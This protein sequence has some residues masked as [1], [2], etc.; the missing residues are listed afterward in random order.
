MELYDKDSYKTELYA[1]VV[2]DISSPRL[3]KVFTYK[4]PAELKYEVYAGCPV[5]VS[6]GSIKALRTAYI[7]DFISEAEL[8]LDRERIKEVYSLAEGE[9]SAQAK[10]I[11]LAYWI[12]NH[13]GTT[14]YKALMTVMPV[15][16]KVLS[17][18]SK[19]FFIKLDK[20]GIEDYIKRLEA[21]RR[22]AWIRLINALSQKDEGLEIGFIRKE[23]N[24]NSNTLARMEKEG[25]ICSVSETAGD[26][27]SRDLFDVEAKIEL[28]E[29]QQQAADIF[30]EDFGSGVNVNTYLLYGITGSGKTEVYMEMIKT[31]LA[32]KRQVIVLIPEINLTYQTVK[33]LINIFGE[34][35]AFINSSMS[36]SERYMQFRRVQEKSADII[37]GPR[38][39]LFAPFDDIGL[40]IIDEEH[41][42]AYK[43]ETVPRYDAREVAAE[44]AGLHNA[45]LVLAS[46]TP[47]VETYKKVL[48]KKIKCLRLTKRAAEGAVLAKTH[49]VNLREELKA[50]NR[51]IFS[52]KL[53]RMIEER[54]ALNE[55]IMLFINRRGYS[56]FVSCRFCGEVIKCRHCDVSLTLHKDNRLRCHYC[57][58]A[59]NLPDS[60]PSC[61]SEYIAAF[62]IGTQQ[63]E[64][65]T[66]KIFPQARI[67]RL[68][69]DSAS[70][71]NGA[72]FIIKQF[73]EHKADILIGT[74][75]IVKG[76]DFSN[77][78][79]VGVIAA[80]V[81][82]YISDY[83]SAEKTFQLITQASGRAGRAGQDSDVVIQTYRPEHYAISCAAAQDF[84]SF[85]KAEAVFRKLAAY[86]PMVHILTVQLS[87]KNEETLN[88]F[89][90]Y[91]FD[92]AKKTAA[93][94]KADIIGPANSR[95]YKVHDFYRKLVYIK[96]IDYDILLEIKSG[97]EEAAGDHS[98]AEEI[99][100]LYDF[101]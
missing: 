30:N 8:S 57:G 16:N 65:L 14:I 99:G 42:S 31:V 64:S 27:L 74:Q 1:Q 36:D 39:A 88:S 7:I 78:S 3:D 40:I 46:A 86:P 96:H 24:I 41:E 52:R 18:A 73:S 82:L 29:E 58:Y 71:K 5:K 47:S 11:A 49:V 9:V 20:D 43:N 93:G 32:K 61:G 15:K 100:I 51:S 84:D 38:S 83:N 97:L 76:H 60:C 90:K 35:V 26:F 87:S 37:I 75:M 95:V 63:L 50:G 77:V 53:K 101:V 2:I 12:K 92:C 89:T 45:A 4:I 79:L 44:L 59:I 19:R 67:L 55:Q 48:D 85:Y 23:L 10:L 28:N 6:F 21:K 70:K 54:L 94:Y 80:D 66:K 25:V 62:G 69:T 22:S 81:S 56:N 13:Y 91:Y 17:R 98:Y 34:R 68:D 72:A 33:R